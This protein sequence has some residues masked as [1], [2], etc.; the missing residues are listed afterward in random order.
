MD[1]DRSRRAKIA[2][3]WSPA[4]G[5]VGSQ[6]GIELDEPVPLDAVAVLVIWP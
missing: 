1:G 2:G 6:L 5:R 4:R 3:P